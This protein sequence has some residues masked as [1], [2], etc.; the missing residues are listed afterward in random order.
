MLLRTLLLLLIVP[1][2]ARAQRD[3]TLEAF[4]RLEELLEM[5]Q[6]DGQLDPKA[7]LPT[8]LVSATP[9]YEASAGWFGT[10]ALQVLVRAFGT[11][12]V[13]LCEACMTLRTEVTGSGL[14]QSSGPIGLDEVVRL[15]D[16]YRGEGERA[17]S[18]VWLDETQS[19][20]AIRIVDLRNG[21]VIFAQ[22]V[23]P[24][25]RSYTG[26]AR[27]FRLAAEVERR[28]RGESISHAFFDAAVYP[29]QHISLEWADQWGDTNANLA[30]FVF[31]AFDPV[32]GL[33]GSY[34]RVLE[35]QHITVGGQVIVSLPTAVANGIADADID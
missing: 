22:V 6:G 5:R 2:V 35:W 21:R 14:V 25:L 28:A 4:E 34:H 15:D 17:R 32:A 9:R 16:L 26:T 20:L 30:G 29:G 1:T 7:V 24:N 3:A 18:G 23:D 10:R 19:G 13:R 27:S 33:G 12:G 31:S 8:I 11:D